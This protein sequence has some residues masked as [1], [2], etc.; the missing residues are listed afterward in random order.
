MKINSTI[1]KILYVPF[2]Q[3]YNVDERIQSILTEKEFFEQC[4][5]MPNFEEE[6]QE[7]LS[8]SEEEIQAFEIDV[9]KEELIEKYQRNKLEKEAFF[10]WIDSNQNEIYCVRGDAGTG[11]TT[12]LHYLEYIY[13]NT[14]LQWDIIDMNMSIADV[15]ILNYKLKI[16][17]FSN[18][19]SKSVSVLIKNIVDD[20]FIYKNYKINIEESFKS[21]MQIVNRYDEL[22]DGTYP[23]NFVK[24][25]FEGI[26]AL[27]RNDTDKKELMENTAQ[28]IYDYWDKYLSQDNEL[29]DA[30]I[31]DFLELYIYFKCCIGTRNRYILAF[32]NLE[33]FIGTDE[34]Y[35]KQLVDFVSKVRHIQKAI[36][37]NNINL[38]YRFQF[39]IF[40]R[41]TS[42]RMFTPQQISEIFPH[43]VDLSEW[44]QSAKIFQK[45]IEWYELNN[46]NVDESE[47]ILDII[48]DI[49]HGKDGNFRGL[50]SKLN[51]LFNNDKRVI[52]NILAKVLADETNSC[53]LETYDF[54]RKNE[55]M[56]D[57]RLAKFAKRVIIFRLVLN[58]LR[59]DGFFSSIAAEREENR[60]NSLGYARKI[61]T[62]LYEHK[63]YFQDGYMKLDDIIIKLDNKERDAVNRYFNGEQDQKR[64]SIISKVLF[65]MNYYDGR[66]DNWLQFI[67]IQY[68]FSQSETHIKTFEE[69]KELVDK[70]HECINI[71]ITS[72]GVAYLFFV[73]YSFE[74]FSCK[75]SKN[76]PV[77]C[78]LNDGSV[79]PLLCVI[80][81]KEELLEE[82]VENLLCIKILNF[83][84]KEAINCIK[85]INNDKKKGT[86]TIPFRKGLNDKYKEHSNR[87]INA[88]VGFIDNYIQCIKELYKSELRE[89]P[90][91]WANYQN[92]IDELEQ[93]KD[94]YLRCR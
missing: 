42:T 14:E 28:Y 21:I 86:K 24:D 2:N 75:S 92:L 43:I 73:V 74:F 45:K 68:N 78:T 15:K 56:I 69:L 20:L 22:F 27:N 18:I 79:P 17:K 19:Y 33:K 84:S 76:A 49:G 48:N 13:R 63:L 82:R 90:I 26:K 66:A 87:I 7:L 65:Y 5:Y 61:L 52:I 16:P 1:N 10:D 71:R 51:M 59:K 80:P 11:K 12:F 32:D 41:N 72:A 37:K 6:I 25:F 31:S 85:K 44:F 34:I 38:S 35:D 91:L 39:A 54:Y 94:R 47:K 62:I 60:K 30:V 57:N 29:M 36:S 67:D 40:M 50:R 9:T 83:V 46:I 23:T 4:F 88:H 77:E 8:K 93:I 55:N 58:E 70:K 89:N 81:K 3:D 53:Y 64:R